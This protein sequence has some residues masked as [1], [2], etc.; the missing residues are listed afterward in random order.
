MPALFVGWRFEAGLTYRSVVLVLDYNDLRDKKGRWIAPIAVPEAELVIPKEVIFPIANASKQALLTLG[1]PESVSLPFFHEAGGTAAVEALTE[2]GGDE[3]HAVGVEGET[4]PQALPNYK[5][6]AKRAYITYERLVKH[7]PTIGCKA[8]DDGHNRHNEQCRNRFHAII[9]AER[10]AANTKDSTQ[11]EEPSSSASAALP[12]IVGA[13]LPEEDHHDELQDACSEMPNQSANNITYLLVKKTEEKTVDKATNNEHSAQATQQSTNNNVLRCEQACFCEDCYERV[14]ACVCCKNPP[15]TKQQEATDGNDSDRRT[16]PPVIPVGEP[17]TTQ[18]QGGESNGEACVRRQAPPAQPV[19]EP[20]ANNNKTVAVSASSSLAAQLSTRGTAITQKGPAR[21]PPLRGVSVVADILCDT[22]ENTV[23]ATSSAAAATANKPDK[24]DPASAEVLF[25]YACSSDSMLGKVAES[26]GIFHVRLHEGMLN[27]T[28]PIAHEQLKS[29]IRANPKCKLWVSIPCTVWSNWQNM[30]LNKIVGYAERLEK[31]R[32]SATRFL[33]QALEIAQLTIDLRGEVAFE[34]PKDCFGWKQPSLTAFISRNN[35]YQ[36]ICTGCATGLTD[37]NG[38]P[39][40]KSWRIVTNNAT[41]ASNL[42]QLRCK[43]DRTFKHAPVEGKYT[44]KTAFYPAA[45][46]EA[47]IQSLFPTVVARHVP[48]MSCIRSDSPQAHRDKEAHGPF[49]PESEHPFAMVTKLLSRKEMLSCPKALAAI[50]AEAEGLLK[51]QTWSLESVRSKR[52]VIRE[53][54][55]SGAT[56]HFGS[57]MTICSI[58]HS[59]ST[60]EGLRKHKARIVFRGDIVRDQHGALAVHQQ[61]GSSPTSMASSRQNLAYGQLAGCSTSQADA[62]RAYIQSK[63]ESKDSS[64][65]A[66]L[67][68]ITLPPELKPTSWS[69][70]PYDDPVVVLEKAL[71]GH[72]DSGGLWE[73]H[74]TKALK[75]IGFIPIESHPSCFWHHEWHLMLTAYVD[76]LLLSG[77]TNQHECC[78]KEL[79]KLVNLEDPTPLGRFL[80]CDHEMFD[81]KDPKEPSAPVKGIRFCMKDYTTQAVEKYQTLAGAKPLKAA[82]TP[83]VSD[84]ALVPSDDEI[85]GELAEDACGVLMK[86]LY[87]ARLARPD[88]LKPINDLAKNVSKWSKNCDKQL[89]R[90]ISYM[91]HTKHYVLE[92]FVGQGQDETARLELKLFVDADFAGERED[93]KST[94]GGWLVLVGPHTY[95]PLT[96]VSKK[97]TSVSRST[98]EAEVISLASSLFQEG[99]PA[100]SLWELLLNRKITLRVQEDNQAT[101]KVVSNGYSPKLR[102]IQRTHKVNLGSITDCFEGDTCVLEYVETSKQ[103]ADIFTKALGPQKWGPALEMLNVRTDLT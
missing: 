54:K 35:L 55:A 83:F 72:P 87:L 29:Q 11:E 8:C 50:Q 32:Q 3:L 4:Q 74:L 47:V 30:S 12:A 90:L 76:D 23:A 13:M 6:A 19:A 21:Q 43:H 33:E 52:E 101:I 58:K 77:P 66:I 16:A 2:E 103:A 5:T 20:L 53:A 59:E 39:M 38:V 91:H 75:Q 24:C 73:R 49:I 10:E 71:Y 62:V 45:L 37:E 100:L 78:W 65:R 46:C 89:L 63:L 18:E 9:T 84:G 31:R 97:Q 28:C 99:L 64:G 36:A 81:G 98:T 88:I 48:A 92:G 86:N 60:D 69:S 94:S 70:L 51:A 82:A 93:A 27:L 22:A 40:L 102:H 17:P 41:L 85:K 44:S 61:L 34:W 96:W 56:V 57:L 26:H 95:F 25:E 80:G 67:T 7:G 79:R 68:W 15:H 14:H 1:R 42:D